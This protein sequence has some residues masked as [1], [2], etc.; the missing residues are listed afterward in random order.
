MNNSN[1][2][3]T[4]DENQSRFITG[5]STPPP[6]PPEAESGFVV[7]D[8][9]F[10]ESAPASPHTDTGSSFITT[11]PAAHLSQATGN[12]WSGLRFA[13]TFTDVEP[14]SEQGAMSLV[15][16]ARLDGRWVIVKRLLPEHRNNLAYIELFFKEYFNGRDLQHEHIVNI[17][18]RG[19]DTDG[20]FFYMEYV[21]GQPLTQRMGENG[22]GNERLIRKIATE[23]LDALSYAH[24][25]QI[26]HR[27]LKP[28][29]VL[30]TNRGDNVKIIDFGLAAADTF[31]DIRG[32]TF[33]GTKKY[34]AP[35][36]N[37]NVK[38][39][40]GRADLYAFGLILLEMFTG[41]TDPDNLEAVRP[42]VRQPFWHEI[43]HKCTRPDPDQRYYNADEVLAVIEANTSQIFRQTET[44]QAP[45]N[46]LLEREKELESK[47]QE[48]W[49]REQQASQPRVYST[50][51]PVAQPPK[52][53]RNLG[54]VW[55]LLGL[56]A[57]IG[58]FYAAQEQD[59]Q[60]TIV[61]LSLLSF[62]IGL[63]LFV[64]VIRWWQ[65]L[66]ALWKLG[67]VVIIG[68]SIY[69][70][71]DQRRQAKQE[72]ISRLTNESLVQTTIEAY[73]DDLERHDYAA[74]QPYYTPVLEQ[75]FDRKNVDASELQ[76]LLAQY[77]ERTPEDQHD[78]DWTR[79]TQHLSED[80]ETVT[81]TFF[82]D[83]H[84]RRRNTTAMK[85][86]RARTVIKLNKDLK[87]FYVAGK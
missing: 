27:D 79:S 33:I 85:T 40:D 80:N 17:Y 63:V 36:Q 25:K 15:Q 56:G 8:D 47:E 48:L 13:S 1:K 59:D 38:S 55:W 53:Q 46:V 54:W 30:I 77:W 50:P 3:D 57:M 22:I 49:K 45:T 35:E 61:L 10:S 19:E 73:Y 68:L 62:G 39:V 78:L 9:A 21:D 31:D 20:P 43:I 26:Y 28:D 7:P 44:S 58:T 37:L 87:I 18:G 16:K 42:A 66:P 5:D 84:Y 29:N 71:V 4:P 34:A 67:I 32:A 14:L 6:V 24:K 69:F 65:R 86:A 81:V 72:I 2:P 41:Q 83:Y 76:T 75:Y 11:E 64:S 70:Y 12:Q 51:T 52:R 74:V 23:L 82:I 60:F